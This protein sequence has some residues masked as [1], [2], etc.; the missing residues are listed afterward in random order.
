M[1]GGMVDLRSQLREAVAGC[2]ARGLLFSAKWAAEQ[3]CSL[4]KANST[5]AT[6]LLT[7]DPAATTATT[8]TITTPTLKG[9][10]RGASKQTTAN[11]PAPP[12][13]LGDPASEAEQRKQRLK[14]LDA[15]DQDI[16]AMAKCL[17]DMREF[18][19]AAYYLQECSGP[20]ARFLRLY[21]Q[22]LNRERRV[23]EAN[24]TSSDT[25]AAS[26]G[27][28]SVAVSKEESERRH[29]LGQ[30]DRELLTIRDEL[31]SI[32]RDKDL[33]SFGL[34]LLAMV[35]KSLKQNSLAQAACLRSIHMYEYNWS[36]WL[37]L[38]SCIDIH[39]PLNKVESMLPSGWMRHA[40]LAH[41]LVELLSSGNEEFLIHYKVLER[42]F[43]TS[44]FVI[45]LR[46]VKH[47]NMREFEEAN[48]LFA[49]LQKLDPYRLDLT[50]IHS[51]ILYVMED[52]A[53]LGE[54]AHRC[55]ALDRFRPETCCVIGNYYSLRREHEKA[56]GYFQRALQ[57][58]SNYL[59]AWTLM[60][61]EYIEMKNTAAAVDAYRHA[62]DVDE[63][64]YRAW[65]GLGQ[66]YEML[67]MPHYAINYYTRATTLRPYDSR[68]WCALANCFELS[69]QPMKAIECYRRAL[70]GTSENEQLAISR[71][72]KLY[73]ECSNAKMAAYYYQL[74]YEH[75]V[76][77]SSS[78]GPGQLD[79]GGT[80]QDELAN[81]CIY[82]ANFEQTRGNVE[83][84][85]RYL[86]QVID[87]ISGSVSAHKVEE[88]KAAMRALV[89]GMQS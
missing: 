86:T 11:T 31:E 21:S 79:L 56:V 78:T 80:N 51:N 59:A 74:M 10:L 29:K 28:A 20:K 34:Y 44:P 83:A 47:Y 18:E 54:L 41:L 88:A 60:G 85:Q 52:R 19:R 75:A 5:A 37:L 32:D 67:K 57:L 71:L 77:D 89:S 33:D 7:M 24:I 65:Y 43:P 82:L 50:D 55:A 9:R 8:T 4:P 39:Q 38:E 70:I 68:M 30:A 13:L 36:A 25:S 14:Q 81:A 27:S 76:K 23:K 15:E 53:K 62:V 69:E 84:A 58:D 63:R 16:F 40:F 26:A 45:G 35:Y 61:H 87:G 72:A 66:T 3:L 42:L 1:D 2:S 6:S 17:F 73:D 49:M 48:G 64:D 46:A 22:Y 12:L